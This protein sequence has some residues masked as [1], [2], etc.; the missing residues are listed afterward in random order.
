[1]YKARCKFYNLRED[2]DDDLRTLMEALHN[3]LGLNGDPF[4]AEI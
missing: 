4:K 3:V 2:K 1:M